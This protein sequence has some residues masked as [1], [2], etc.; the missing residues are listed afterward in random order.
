MQ[1]VAEFQRFV[2]GKMAE[3]V[4]EMWNTKNLIQPV[5]QLIRS[6]K[7]QY[8]KMRL[9]ENNGAANIE[10]IVD[11]IHDSKGIA[12]RKSF[13]EKDILDAEDYNT[14]VELCMESC[15]FQ[16]GSL[17]HKLDEQVF[18]PETDEI[19]EQAMQ[20]CTS[21]FDNIEKAHH[22]NLVVARDVMELSTLIKEPEVFS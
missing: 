10:E 17:H 22:A 12:W 14:I 18:D 5:R 7:L 6:L 21:L 13:K 16:K 11:T 8:N 15:L 9:F 4:K 1:E 20:K 3:L 19:K 2:N